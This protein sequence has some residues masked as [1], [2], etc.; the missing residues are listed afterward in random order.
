MKFTNNRDEAIYIC[1]VLQENEK[2][3]IGIFGKLQEGDVD[4]AKAE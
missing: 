4:F 3:R 2:V 1:C